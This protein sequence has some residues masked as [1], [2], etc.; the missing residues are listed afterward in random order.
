MAGLNALV[1]KI[2]GSDDVEDHIA[3]ACESLKRIHKDKP[4]ERQF[5]SGAHLQLI[6]EH[7]LPLPEFQKPLPRYKKHYE[8]VKELVKKIAGDD[9]PE[10]MISFLT[11]QF[12]TLS[13]REISW[14]SIF[15]QVEHLASNVSS[16][17]Y[18][19][20]MK[21]LLDK[22]TNDEAAAFFYKMYPEVVGK[23]ILN[24]PVLLDLKK[25]C[26][27]IAGLRRRKESN[28]HLLNFRRSIISCLVSSFNTKQLRKA[29]WEVAKKIYKSCKRKRDEME[30]FLDI[31][32]TTKAGRKPIAKELKD[33]IEKLWMDNSRAAAKTLVT[34]PYN[35]AQRR[36]GRRLLRPARHIIIASDI[37]R[38][39]RASY[40]TI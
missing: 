32:P 10:T 7:L 12:P 9:N 26:N 21:K 27:H 34:N 36:P 15:A 1:S 18:S 23:E 3:V 25:L 13:N 40:G 17:T 37:Y 19:F 2:S 28:E 31:D 24:H 16:R 35:R 4:K 20:E 22:F 33:E 6:F 8:S 14:S 38:E 30:E 5:L 39:R 11:S 29:G